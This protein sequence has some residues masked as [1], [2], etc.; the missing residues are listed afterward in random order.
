M[1][2]YRRLSRVFC[3]V[4][5]NPLLEIP[6]PHRRAPPRAIL[7]AFNPLLEIRSAILV[8][9]LMNSLSLSI[10]FLRFLDCSG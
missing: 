3:Y 6:N 2:A 8:R 9:C 4:A 7:E 5:F 1:Y 10:L